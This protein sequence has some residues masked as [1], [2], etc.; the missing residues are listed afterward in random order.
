M[1]NCKA[2]KDAKSMLMKMDEMLKEGRHPT[3]AEM[4]E[5]NT[6]SD[7]CD[8]MMKDKMWMMY[9]R[10]TRGAIYPDDTKKVFDAECATKWVD[11]MYHKTT[12]G[13]KVHGEHWDMATTTKVLEGAGVDFSTITLE[14]GYIIMNMMWHDHY[15]SAVAAGM[16]NNPEF[17]IALALDMINDDDSNV[18]VHDWLVIKYK[19]YQK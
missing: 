11:S 10:E 1:H 19:M 9:N 8:R 4:A 15:R 17:Y 5:Y 14:E 3:T 12:S 2:C 7:F 6:V 13:A 18:S 16:E